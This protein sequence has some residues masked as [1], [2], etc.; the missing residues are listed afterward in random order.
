MNNF[1]QIK[2]DVE[3]NGSS[4]T[5]ILVIGPGKMGTGIALA[6]AQ[7]DFPVILFGRN[8]A[9]L[10]K[11]MALIDQSLKEG[12]DKGVFTG[13]VAQKIKTRISA[14][15]GD[16]ENLEMG[17]I[18]MVI[19]AIKEDFTA[20][21]QL[22]AQLDFLMPP[23]A[24]LATVTSS[25]N[26]ERLSSQ[27]KKPERFLWTHFFYPAQKNRTVELSHLEQ[28]SAQALDLSLEILVRAKREVI[29]LKKYR[30][31][32][33][34][35]IILIGLILEALRLIDEGFEA[36]L[37]DEASR[38]AFNVPYGF[39]SLLPLLGVETALAAA[40]SLAQVSD[41]SDLLGLTYDNFFSLPRRLQE[42][43]D[44]EGLDGLETFL[45]GEKKEQDHDTSLDPL[46]LELARQRFQ[47][48]AFMTAAEVVEAGLID[49]PACDRLCQLAF[50]WSEGPFTMMN[51][52]GIEASLRLV[53]ER[54]ELS[55]R[56]EINFPVPRNLIERA[57]RNEL[58]PLS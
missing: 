23:S 47:A 6:F 45:K 1:S 36:S 3:S 21:S 39:I 14:R 15:S 38:L 26:A 16:L 31:G 29:T 53:T 10:E 19:E 51:R 2:K 41:P 50:S 5:E 24:I 56:R 12:V 13:E 4:Q 44:K 35:N 58:W 43:L 55:H 46:V 54:M 27:L 7:N 49:P 48:V 34:A 37:V 20:K 17:S 52:M 32:G 25:L 57:Q 40:S 18:K 22:L 8:K 30:R 11:G 28:T 42:L 9:S 33:V